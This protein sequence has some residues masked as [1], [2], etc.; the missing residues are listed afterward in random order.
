MLLVPDCIQRAIQWLR[1]PLMSRPAAVM[2][3][4]RHALVAAGRETDVGCG[5]EIQYSGGLEPRNFSPV[6]TM[7]ARQGRIVLIRPLLAGTGWRLAN[8]HAFLD[9]LNCVLNNLMASLRTPFSQDLY[10]ICLG[11]L[12]CLAHAALPPNPEAVLAHRRVFSHTS[13]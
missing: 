5:R 13:L 6:A 8:L 3:A 12:R 7:Q 9:K 1:K 4:F 10:I 11:C 2:P